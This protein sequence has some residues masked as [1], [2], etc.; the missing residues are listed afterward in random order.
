MTIPEPVPALKEW[1]VVCAALGQGLQTITLRK[2][3][4][5]EE[6]GEFR[7]RFPKFLL[8][9]TREHQTAAAIQPSYRHLLE[10]NSPQPPEPGKLCFDLWA[11]FERG[12]PILSR[13]TA[14]ALARFTVW[15]PDA[16]SK[17]F[18]LYPEKPMILMILRVHKL[19]H[20]LIISEDPSYAGC[21]SWVPL[22]N[23]RPSPDLTGPPVLDHERFTKTTVEIEHVIR[24]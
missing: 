11:T 21:R 3:G 4:I 12:Y 7:P 22:V 18:D 23:F 9:P 8:Y 13:K 24:F 19:P 16:L 20:P 10:H 5:E 17:R 6:Q 15:T 1:Q 14:L 2:G